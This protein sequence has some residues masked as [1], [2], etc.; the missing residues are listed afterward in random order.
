MRGYTGQGWRGPGYGFG[1]GWAGPGYGFGR[2]WGGGFG[3]RNRGLRCPWRGFGPG[4]YGAYPDPYE[5]ESYPGPHEFL[6]GVEEVVVSDAD[7][8]LVEELEA[9]GIKVTRRPG[10]SR[11]GEQA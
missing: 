1:R 10:G 7:P 4:F 8:R 3:Y 6:R 11:G 9:M 2:G 5:Q